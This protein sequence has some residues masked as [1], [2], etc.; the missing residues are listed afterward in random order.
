MV[1][2]YE[3]LG[4]SP[5]SSVDE[6]KSAIAQ[7][8]TNSTLPDNVLNTAKK[9][10]LNEDVRRQY[11]AKLFAEYPDL[12]KKIFDKKEETID[13]DIQS[14]VRNVRYD[15]LY[16][17]LHIRRFSSIDVVERAIA[18]AIKQKRNQR[19]I[20]LAKN[21]LTNQNSKRQY[22]SALKTQS[23]EFVCEDDISFFKE[24]ANNPKYM[25]PIPVQPVQ[26]EQQPEKKEMSTTSFTIVVV[27]IICI[28]VAYNINS[29]KPLTSEDKLERLELLSQGYVKN[30]L[31]NPSSAQFRNVHGACGE[32]N[33]KN[34]FGGYSGFTRY[35]GADENMVILEGDGQMIPSEFEAAWQGCLDMADEWNK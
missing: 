5:F 2:I 4:I 34:S 15:D 30:H 14:N 9:W 13:E 25:R 11:N 17:F 22:D 18:K 3:K 33:A 7:H 8:Y 31:K 32:V 23:L 10:L 27:F 28:I 12:I 19:Y 1:N 6:I 26:I 29:N 21:Y 20:F 24:S 16:H 35:I